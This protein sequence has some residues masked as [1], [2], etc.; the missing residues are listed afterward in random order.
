MKR[1]NDASFRSDGIPSFRSDLSSIRAEQDE[2]GWVT[3]NPLKRSGVRWL[4]SEVFSTIQ[5]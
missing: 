5:V 2:A 1:E 4:H 3:L